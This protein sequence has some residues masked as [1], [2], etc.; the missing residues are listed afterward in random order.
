MKRHFNNLGLLILNGLALATA[1][2]LLEYEVAKFR[3]PLAGWIPTPG[4]FDTV[5]ASIVILLSIL[6]IA[7][8]IIIYYKKLENR[9]WLWSVTIA[10]WVLLAILSLVLNTKAIPIL[11]P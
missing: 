10:S 6:V 1:L 2:L 7:V 4:V 8:I 5:I 11:F 9:S 3:H